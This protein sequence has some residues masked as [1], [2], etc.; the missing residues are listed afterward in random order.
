MAQLVDVP[1][2]GRLSFPDGMSEA[3]MAEAIQ[4]NFPKMQPPS[5]MD[6]VGRAIGL[7][8]RDVAS[9]VAALPNMVA[10]L[11]QTVYNAA[12]GGVN[13]LGGNLP[14]WEGPGAS[15][16]F[17]Q[18]LTAMGLPAPET[19]QE[20]MV[21][22]VSQGMGGA[23]AGRVMPIPQ[24]P[25][26]VASAPGIAS[27]AAAVGRNAV[28][29]GMVAGATAGGAAQGAAELGIDN[30]IALQV[31]GMAGG[32]L[33]GILGAIP[34]WS[35]RNAGRMLEEAV[36]MTTPEEW[37]YAE[38]LLAKGRDIAVP[39]TGPE[40]FPATAPIQQLA[41]KVTAS[42]TGGP[43]MDRVLSAR[44][45]RMET[46]A[47][48]RMTRVGQNV[49]MQ[50]AANQAQEAATGVIRSEEIART[51]AVTPYYKAAETRVTPPNQMQPAYQE[52][53]RQA[54]KTGSSAIRKSLG[55]L[56]IDLNLA[57]DNV[58]RLM[59]VVKVWKG[60][61]DAPPIRAD[62]IDKNTG[63]VLGKVLDQIEAGVSATAPEYVQG[64]RVFQQR[65]S[66]VLDPLNQGPVGKVA[67]VGYEPDKAAT[68]SRVLS[69]FGGEEATPQRLRVLAA[70]LRKQDPQAFPNVA[71]EYLE[72]EFTKAFTDTQSGP[73]RMAGA[74]FRKAIYGSE[75]QRENL[76]TIIMETAKAQGQ[77]PS[78]VWQGFQKMLDV[79]EATGRTPGTGSQ[80]DLRGEMGRM[81]RQS[82]IGGA[83][84]TVS[85]TPTRAVSNWWR[86][87][88]SRGAYRELAEVFT[89][90]D[91]IA[92]MRKIAK[93]R[94]GS[95]A[96]TQ[97]VAAVIGSTGRNSPE[98]QQDAGA[99]TER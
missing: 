88:L 99:E 73:N 44:N 83:L 86:D 68:V 34:G 11:P 96:A 90:P 80:T 97:A 31:I 4:R 21:S 57:G 15:G 12:A 22:A 46:A 71:R 6:R 82:A 32:A 5:T 60:K 25:V 87:V 49:G 19:T 28:N 27:G 38:Q 29:S 17:Q 76:K 13:M 59:D 45:A 98:N 42:Q 64:K 39:L 94:S 24:P 74:N 30:P 9:A 7:G 37:Q 3:Q 77:N 20:R 93:L 50:E 48:D 91:A 81:S 72:R 1:G 58:G 40:G 16:A 47:N 26:A 23:L 10:D 61:I 67:G 89:A 85:A 33:P 79:F 95:S 43:G 52:I 14:R 69:E 8:V 55:D 35:K 78:E 66:M 18:G 70:E 65:T 36:R 2:V 75:K 63:R 84:D 53:L 51:Q 92:Q 41:S 54:D 56:E 62:A